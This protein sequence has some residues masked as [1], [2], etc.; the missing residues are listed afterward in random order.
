MNIV[1][2][3]FGHLKTVNAHRKEVKKLMYRCG[4]HKQG[5]R[6]DLSKYSIIEF[7]NGVRYFTGTKSPHVGERA[8]K[9]YSEAW[10]HH[11]ARNKHHPE[12]WIDIIGGLPTPVEIPFKYII[13]MF[14]DRVAASKTYLKEKYSDRSP[15]EYYEMHKNEN[16]MH[17]KTR[18]KIEFYLKHLA[19]KGED[20]TFEMIKSQRRNSK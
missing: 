2:R 5:R 3:F 10:L 16:A 15:L 8:D 17:P 14:C 13:E 9:G 4:L 6:H 11:K 19:E 18:E 7:V 1:K 20:C 12:Y